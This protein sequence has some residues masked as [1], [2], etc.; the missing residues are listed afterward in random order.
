MNRVPF[1]ALACPL[2]GTKLEPDVK[3]KSAYC[4]KKHC[5]DFDRYGTLNLLPVQFKKSKE[6]GDSKEM[7]EARQRFLNQ[8]FY[9]AISDTVNALVEEYIVTHP[10]N[11]AFAILDAACG[12][13]Y[14]ASEL[15]GHMPSLRDDRAFSIAGIDI[16]KE[17]IIAAAR[18]DRSLLW[19]VG[20]NAH[21]PVLNQSVDILLS[22]FGFP[23]WREF[24][25]VLKKSGVIIDV[26]VGPDHLIELRRVLYDDIKEPNAAP[27]VPQGMNLVTERRLT[28]ALPPINAGYLEDLLIMTPHGYRATAARKE[29]ALETDFDALTLD[30]FFRVFAC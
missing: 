25:R 27:P 14:Y 9:K 22:M 8:G 18:R 7:V 16:S 13:G 24:N 12:E 29:Q 17:A 19:C 3:G 4:D 21:L 5:F 23:V 15:V 28:T 10:D 20:T 30:V 1:N 6:P 26:S 2:E 11:D